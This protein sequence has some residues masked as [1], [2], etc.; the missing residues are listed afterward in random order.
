VATAGS[1]SRVILQQLLLVQSWSGFSMAGENG[2]CNIGF[3]TLRC[4]HMCALF[5]ARRFGLLL[6]CLPIHPNRVS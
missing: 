5:Q 2:R 6:S 1:G 4:V 3:V